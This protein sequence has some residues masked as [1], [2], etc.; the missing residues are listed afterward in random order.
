MSHKQDDGLFWDK[1]VMSSECVKMKPIFVFLIKRVLLNLKGKHLLF[2]SVDTV[3]DSTLKTTPAQCG[4]MFSTS[5]STDSKCF[6]SNPNLRG[7]FS[8]VS[9]KPENH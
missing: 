3:H 6:A 4:F 9:L 5:F 1:S 8:L 7:L 2:L